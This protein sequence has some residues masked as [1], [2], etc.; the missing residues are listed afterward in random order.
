MVAPVATATPEFP[1]GGLS[2]SA[3]W[4]AI[5][6]FVG[7]GDGEENELNAPIDGFSEDSGPG[8]GGPT[9]DGPTASATE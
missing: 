8:H 6:D 7:G 9:Q 3:L 4:D 1:S 5:I 2:L